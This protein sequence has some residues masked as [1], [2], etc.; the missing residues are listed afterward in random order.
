[1]TRKQHYPSI[2]SIS[3]DTLRNEDLIPCFASELGYH[4]ARMRLSRDQRKVFNKLLREIEHWQVIAGDNDPAW[5]GCEIVDELSD[6]LNQI[7]PPYCTFGASDGDGACFGFWPIV[8][9]DELPRVDAG[10]PIP[11]ECRGEDIY[12]VNDHGNVECG[13]VDRRGKFHEYW[14]AV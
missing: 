5:D 6:A 4:M 12:I 8:D 1:M 9:H 3:S 2:G 14:S 10:D 13:Y 7:A 11:R